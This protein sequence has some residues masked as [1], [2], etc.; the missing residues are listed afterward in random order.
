MVTEYTSAP[1][2]RIGHQVE[3]LGSILTAVP[4]PVI[5]HVFF[6]R[7]KVVRSRFSMDLEFEMEKEG[8]DVDVY[9]YKSCFPMLMMN[10]LVRRGRCCNF[11]WMLNKKENQRSSRIPG[12]YI[13][14]I[15]DR[16]ASQRV[17]MSLLNHGFM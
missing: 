12:I 17:S 8:F 4:P 11:V 5:S 13:Q 15:E 7:C 1:T 9:R 10:D 16:Q 2:L 3:M 6:V 14:K